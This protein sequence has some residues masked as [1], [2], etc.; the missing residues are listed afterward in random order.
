MNKYAKIS[1]ENQ[2]K[3]EKDEDKINVQILT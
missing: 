2:K 3:T 1:F